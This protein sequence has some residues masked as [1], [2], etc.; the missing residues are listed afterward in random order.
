M[1]ITGRKIDGNQNA[2]VNH[3][4]RCGWTVQSLAKVGGGAPDILVGVV[5]PGRAP[6]NVLIELK[7]P[8]EQLNEKQVMWHASWLGRVFV[9]HDEQQAE[10]ICRGVALE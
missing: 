8:G 3:L 4:R 7:S 10:A 5:V 1:S 6:T 9:A 2:I